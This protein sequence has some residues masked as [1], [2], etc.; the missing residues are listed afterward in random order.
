MKFK[1]SYRLR[2]GDEV[3]VDYDVDAVQIIPEIDL[4][5]LYE[6]DE[7]VVINKPVGLLTH[8]KGAFNPEATVATWLEP[9][10]TQDLPASQK[11]STI[12]DLV[13]Y[14]V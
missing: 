12:P 13:S 8:S 14:I 3:V 4:P 1:I 11:K 5:I 7:C 6:D 9:K 2:L 10:L